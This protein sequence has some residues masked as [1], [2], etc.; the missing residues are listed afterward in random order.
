QLGQDAAT[1]WP[2]A[3]WRTASPAA[4]GVDG[5]A[6]ATLVSRLRS[7]A[8]G[9]EHSIVIVRKGYV[10][11]DEYFAGWTSD[12]IHTEQSVT[13][14]V[15]S[16]VTGIALARG[17]V[18]S[19]DQPL[20]ELLSRYAPIANLDDRKRALRVRDLLTMRSGLDWNEDSYPGSPLEQLN[21]LTTD[22][23][24]FVVDWPMREQPGTRWQYNSGGVIALGGAIGIA[25]G[26]NTA[27]YARTYLLRPIGVTG[28]KWYRGFPDLL[29]HTGGGLLMSTRDLARVGYL[30]LR[31]GK[32]N[33]TQVVPEAWIAESTRPTVT[34]TYRL[35]GRQ[36][37]YGYLWWLY[38]LS[39]GTPDASTADL[40]IAAS[41]AQGQWLF[42]VPKH[43]LVVAINA[44]ITNGP[45][46]ALDM[47]F[48]T[49]IPAMR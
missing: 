19:L 21:N 43:D 25:G 49:I 36:S 33:T 34:P 7:G 48:G 2:A 22:W 1:Y 24:R 15:T 12:S 13:K 27:D 26:M 6:I 8:L 9:A 29:P 41:G 20:V 40:V 47:L 23:L 35:G 10:I 4:V 37:S 46:P 42:I 11:A 3:T 14:S 5:A 28:D 44:G 32:W 18:R 17:D 31:R 16:L 45:D 38:T 39:G 30:V